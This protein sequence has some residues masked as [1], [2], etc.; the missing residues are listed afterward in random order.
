MPSG[1]LATKQNKSNLKAQ[2]GESQLYQLGQQVEAFKHI[3]LF[4]QLPDEDPTLPDCVSILHP[5][6]WKSRREKIL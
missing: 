4:K 2:M 3:S 1:V 6:L 5:Q